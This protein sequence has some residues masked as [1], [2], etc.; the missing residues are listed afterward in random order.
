MPIPKA[1]RERASRALGA[2]PAAERAGVRWV[3][4]ENLHLT[5]RFL[6]E[7]DE[8]QGAAAAA[9]AGRAA[10]LAFPFRYVVA[11]LDAFPNWQ[12][13]RTVVLR[14]DDPEGALL[15]LWGR[16]ETELAGAGFGLEARSFRPH[17]TL[18]RS[19]EGGTRLSPGLFRPEEVPAREIVLYRSFLQPTG[20]VY[21]S[22]GSWSLG[23]GSGAL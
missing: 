11:G 8:A 22:L 5:L 2:F 1:L 19:R 16:L 6:G 13:V 4:A 9:A 7:V 3:A 23:S 17:I 20:P 10:A 21:Q 12:A 14:V 18:G 15:A